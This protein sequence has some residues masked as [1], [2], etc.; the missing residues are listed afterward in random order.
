MFTVMAKLLASNQVK[1][2][3]G[4]LELMGV[5]DCFTPAVTYVEIL[6]VLMKSGSQFIIYNSAKKAGFDWFKTMSGVYKGLKQSEAI[7]WGLDIVSLSGWGVLTLDSV[8][9]EKKT[10]VFVLKN[11]IAAKVFGSSSVQVDHLFRGLAAGGMSYILNGDLECIETHCLAKGDA[12]CRFVVA[13]MKN[14]K[15]DASALKSDFGV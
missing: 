15:I 14:L 1:F 3:D 13:P 2:S 5:R 9:I 10:C 6:R 11:S 8:D 7:K 4:R 12:L